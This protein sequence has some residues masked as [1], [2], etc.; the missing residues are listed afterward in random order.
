[1]N[2]PLL[3]FLSLPP[4]WASWDHLPSKLR[5]LSPGLRQ[6]R[7][8]PSQIGGVN[9]MWE[10]PEPRGVRAARGAGSREQGAVLLGAGGLEG[11]E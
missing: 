1:M 11:G 8:I 6:C 7:G 5:L 3:F 2:S 4:R 9:R 10:E